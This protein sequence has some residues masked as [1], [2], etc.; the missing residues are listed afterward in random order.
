MGET[1]DGRRARSER[2]RQAVI[3]AV[4]EL[5]QAGKVLPTAETIAERAGVSV[6]SLFRHFDGIADLQL[7]TY[8]HFRRHFAPL[9]IVSAEQAA[10]TRAERIAVLVESR[11]DL[12]EQAGAVMILG[13]LRSLEHDPMVVA[14]SNTAACS[15]IRCARCWRSI[16]AMPPRRAAPTS[17][18]SSMR[19]RHSSRGT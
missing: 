10:G 14:A 4:V 8:E 16:S 6:A 13:R 5:V 18:P 11:L 1:G 2:S 12:Y 19:S 9:V 7:Q 17:P 15:P 3:D